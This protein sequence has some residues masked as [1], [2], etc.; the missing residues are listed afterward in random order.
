M[1]HARPTRL[2]FGPYE[3]DLSSRQLLENGTVVHLQTKPFKF[4]A[5][6]L[7]HEGEVVTREAISHSIWPDIYV[8]IDQGLNA[9]ARKVRL[10]LKDDPFN[11]TYFQTVGS[12]G[13]KFIHPV[14]VL[15]WSPEVT[16]VPDP[17]IRLAVLPFA[18]PNSEHAS[19][20]S[21][22]ALELASCIGRMHPRLTV[23]TGPDARILVSGNGHLVAIRKAAEVQYVLSGS[24]S[25]QS[26]RIQVALTLNSVAEGHPVWEQSFETATA[27][28]SCVLP[29]IAK[30]IFRSFRN[31]SPSP[32]K[33]FDTSFGAYQE[34]LIARHFHSART[35]ADCTLACARYEK[36]LELD[37]NFS[38]AYARFAELCNLGAARG[39][40]LPKPTYTRASQ[41]AKHALALDPTGTEAMV[42]L[43]WSQLAL[44][45]DWALATR[46]FERTLNL[47]PNDPLVYCHY[48]YLLL[49]RGRRDDAVSALEKAH[50]LD[51]LL[52]CIDAHL[53]TI[54]YFARRYDDVIR[55]AESTLA[56]HPQST[57]AQSYF[58]LAL[59]AKGDHAK[60]IKTLRDAAAES[61]DPV[62]TAR[63]AYAKAMAGRFSEAETLIQ[64]LEVENGFR[65]RPTYQIACIRL[66]LGNINEALALLETAYQQCSHWVLLVGQDPRLELLRG[67]RRFDQ[68]CRMMRPAEAKKVANSV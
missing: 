60:A 18:V 4:L 45:R 56:L 12:R 11:P 6:L 46:M 28:L 53:L 62:T 33:T 26:G 51:P 58:A 57:E 30:Q 54:Y 66:A 1:D 39:W 37:P 49:S 34:Y 20:A 55:H 19:I 2:R 50:R 67:S 31:L 64:K 25:M 42:A 14:E 22:L 21:G 61:S 35:S 41:L 36:A 68:L 15:R 13:Y 7:L 47:H 48:G 63:L 27:D 23:I 16:E 40:M 44:N 38:P 59:L 3:V 5:T 24:L 65:V 29:E 43:G 52:A 8:Q 17:P 10:A 32:S 9:A